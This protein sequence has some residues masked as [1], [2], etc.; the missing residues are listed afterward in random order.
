MSDLRRV[1]SELQ[2]HAERDLRVERWRGR[3]RFARSADVRY[4]GQGYELNVPLSERLLVDFHDEHRR[5]YGYSHPGR[6]VE[7]VT[8][9]LRASIRS[10]AVPRASVPRA[11]ATPP[12]LVHAGVIFDGRHLATAIFERDALVPEKRHAGPAVVTEYSATTVIPPKMRFHADRVGNLIVE[13]GDGDNRKRERSP[14]KGSTP[15]RPEPR[16]A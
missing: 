1:F 10:P 5:R 16:V 3:A 11:R 12:A 4:R 6:E 2:K 9:R 14:P 7:I 15:F 8:L 13:I